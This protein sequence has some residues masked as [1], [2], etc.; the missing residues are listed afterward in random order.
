MI[1]YFNKSSACIISQLTDKS[2][3]INNFMVTHFWVFKHVVFLRVLLVILV[4][5]LYP[6]E[7][8]IIL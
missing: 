3:A 2:L 1:S 5:M 4:S 7:I 8:T 6:L